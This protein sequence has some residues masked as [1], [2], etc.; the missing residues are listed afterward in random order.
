MVILGMLF[1][2]VLVLGA[3]VALALR[4][5]TLGEAQTEAELSHDD[6]TVCYDVPAGQDPVVLVSALAHAGFTARAQLDAG[7]ERLRVHCDDEDRA[8]VRSIIERVHTSG[9]EGTSVPSGPVRF[10]DER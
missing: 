6:A 5:W 7:Q 9:V 4:V 10:T 2:G 8:T 3:L 1:V